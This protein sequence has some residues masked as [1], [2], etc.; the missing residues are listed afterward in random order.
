MEN[1]KDQCGLEHGRRF[2]GHG[3]W[4]GFNLSFLSTVGKETKLPQV[5]HCL[6]TGEKSGWS[7]TNNGVKLL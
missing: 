5:C 4:A 3:R 2:S 1:W 6:F 7:F